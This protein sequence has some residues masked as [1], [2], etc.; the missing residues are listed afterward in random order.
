MALSLGSSDDG[1]SASGLEKEPD[2]DIYSVKIRRDKIWKELRFELVGAEL[3]NLKKSDPLSDD[4]AVVKDYWYSG[5]AKLVESEKG[6]QFYQTPESKPIKLIADYKRPDEDPHWVI[7]AES[8]EAII[9]RHLDAYGAGEKFYIPKKQGGRGRHLYLA[10]RMPVDPLMRFEIRAGDDMGGARL[11]TVD[12]K[13]G[14][15]LASGSL[16][17]PIDRRTV[18]V[19]R[20]G[21]RL[22]TYAG[23]VFFVVNLNK[24]KK[25]DVGLPSA[26]REN[27]MPINIAGVAFTNDGRPIVV[28]QNGIVR[29]YKK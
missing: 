10:Y 24:G 19:S 23:P 27:G 9:A 2:K 17:V 20:D 21:E 3:T 18:A 14:K 4:F 16:P 26:F 5:P 12:L 6:L 15:V 7:M 29:I 11:Y 22:I 28:G 25:I 8:K 13:S 1:W